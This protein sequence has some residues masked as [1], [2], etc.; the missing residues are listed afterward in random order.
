M[1]KKRIISLILSL[2]LVLSVF[3]VAPLS[4][5]AEEAD[6]AAEG[7]TSGTTGDCT[8]V[9][10][11]TELTISGSGSMG[12]YWYGDAPW[13]T[14]ITKLTINNGVTNVGERAFSDCS[15][16][17]SVSIPD[18]V[19]IIGDWAFSECTALTSIAIPDSVTDIGR[20]A[21]NGCTALANIDLPGSLS[22]ICD[23]AFANCTSLTSIAIPDSVTFINNDAFNGCTGLISV[24]LPDSLTAIYPG[25]FDGCTSL[26]AITIP[27]SVEIIYFRA[28]RN[29]ASIE[30]VYIP[31]SVE[32]IYQDAFNGCANLSSITVD[33]SNPVY[34]SRDNCNAVIKTASDSLLFGCKS[35]VI[36]DS[37]TTIEYGAFKDCTGLTEITI[38]DNV[39][40]IESSAFSGCTGLTSIEL[41]DSITCINYCTFEGCTGLT[42]F[43]IPDSVTTIESNAFSY[44]TALESIFI[45]A[46]VE[47]IT[48][49]L[50]IGCSALESI[51]VDP[52]NPVYDS[53]E[54]CNAIIE[55][56]T[57]AVFSGCNSTAFPDSVTSIG[58]SAFYRRT[59]LTSITI[60]DTITSIGEYAFYGC[61]NLTSVSFPDSI[62]VISYESFAFTGLTSVI[63][64]DSVERV[65]YCAFDCCNALTSAVV[66]YNVVLE[67]NSFVNCDNLTI[68][69]YAGSDAETYANEN[70]I[71]F[72]ALDEALAITKQ[73]ASWKGLDGDRI[74][75]SVSASGSGLSYRWYYRPAGKTKWIATDDTDSC[76]DSVTMSKSR[77]GRQVYCKITDANG[78]VINS[79]IAT[80]SY[81]ADLVITS[82]P[83]NWTGLDGE[84]VSI[85]VTAQGEGLSYKWY[86]RRAGKLNW[87]AADD[88]DS[89]YDN[90][91]MSASRSG[92]EVYC[93]ITDK[94]GRTVSSDTATISYP[95]EP[96]ITSQP[97]S[98]TGNNGEYVNI[99]VAAQGEGLTYRWY[100][101]PAG[102]TNWIATDDTDSCYDS[103]TMSKSRNGRQVYCRITDKY[104]RTLSSDVVTISYPD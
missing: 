45:P 27:E 37:V 61:S 42:S 13:G 28:F 64:P 89:C 54:N 7:A 70:N 4:A 81:P 82:Q 34:D 56:E 93:K 87:V 30:S 25:L 95:P 60:P 85:S 62:T 72:V 90:I 86:Y 38:P 8:W 71:P 40:S 79:D 20:S 46:S 3:S 5:A 96:V 50:F 59:G 10:N 18:S 33:P 15:E 55:T 14:D 80:I 100:Y 32:S 12:T 97:E 6:I 16:L 17:T 52:L 83:E 24:S 68:Y 75:I 103:V 63:I 21:F 67:T 77:S 51:T 69:G 66:P 78:A 43:T 19:T 23:F 102:K 31:A 22:N 48:G 92:R 84:Q 11:G 2:V 39:T 94:Y 44:C 53:R 29:C 99:S 65:E 73:P 41:P 35:T 104:G 9:L 88:T 26:S 58:Y 101:R 74:E 76:Y 47:N 57:D 1:K 49:D 98:W 36:P 91:A